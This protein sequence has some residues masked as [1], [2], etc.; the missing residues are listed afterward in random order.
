MLDQRLGGR[1]PALQSASV[2]ARPG[3][4]SAGGKNSLGRSGKVRLIWLDREDRASVELDD[5]GLRAVV[6][7]PRT[8]HRRP[9]D[10]TVEVVGLL[11][12]LPHLDDLE[13]ILSGTSDVKDEARDL[14]R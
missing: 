4:W 3:C 5:L 14:L 13:T 8:F 9:P 11:L 2:G 10:V 1:A 12:R 6:G 7:H